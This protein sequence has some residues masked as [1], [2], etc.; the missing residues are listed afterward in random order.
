MASRHGY[1]SSQSL[2][3]FRCRLPWCRVSF[4]SFACTFVS[5]AAT[6]QRSNDR[7]RRHPRAGDGRRVH[8]CRRRR[9]RGVVEPGGP[10]RRRLRQRAHGVRQAAASAST[11]AGHRVCRAAYPALGITYYRLPVSQIRRQP[12][13][14]AAA[15]QTEKIRR[16]PAVCG[17]VGASSAV[18][19]RVTWSSEQ[20]S[21]CCTRGRCDR[22]PRRRRPMATFG[23]VRRRVATLRNRDRADRYGAG[24]D[25]SSTLDAARPGRRCAHL[26]AAR[27]RSA[28]RRCRRISI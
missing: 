8:G 7:H 23:P 3:A 14:A 1:V 17:A 16:S 13:T 24:A 19:R 11:R 9:L 12:S 27:G 20:P 28:V 5:L 21:S 10:R 2:H 26:G 6:R 15:G 18:N 22:G 25:S 4:V